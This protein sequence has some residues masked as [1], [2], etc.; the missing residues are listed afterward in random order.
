MRNLL[1]WLSGHLPARMITGDNNERY[2]E[3]YYIA[4]AFGCELYL[5]RFLA[6]DP[7]RGFHNHPWRWAASLVLAGSYVEKLFRADGLPKDRVRKAGHFTV[8][9]PD[10]L[11]RVVILDRFTGIPVPDQLNGLLPDRQRGKDCWTLFAVGPRIEYEKGRSWGFLRLVDS[12]VGLH[13]WVFM[14][15]LKSPSKDWW[16]TA[17][18]GRDLR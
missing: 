14:P 16:K 18:K 17:P 6:S 1:Y 12:I 15:Y 5:H 2:L 9:G 3:R 13:A 11:H 8:F 7:D 10:H 4:R